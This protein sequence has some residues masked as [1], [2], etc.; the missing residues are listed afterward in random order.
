MFKHFL[1]ISWRNILHNKFYT[2]LLV[3]G[4]AVGIASSLL[5]G[6]YTW[7][8]LTYDNF[9]EKKDRVFLVG[10]GSKEGTEA[11]QSGWTTPPTGP[12]LQEFF[13]EIETSSRLCL[14]FDEVVVSKDEKK[15]T[16][17]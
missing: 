3:A 16:P 11:S 17:G 6:L 12:A 2:I 10:V 13:P 1:L 15:Y 5:V 4:L 8:E 14:W 9:H 7:H